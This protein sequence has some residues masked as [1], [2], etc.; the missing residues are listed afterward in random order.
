[1]KRSKRVW[2]T[3]EV[4]ASEF[5]I[6]PRTLADRLRQMGISAGKEGYSTQQ[7]VKAIYGDMAGERLRLV[8][9]QADKL[10]LENSKERR[11]AVSLREL[12]PLLNR[13][14]I[15][16]KAEITSI[17]YIERDDKDKILLKCGELCELALTDRPQLERDVQA[18][19]E[20]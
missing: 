7:M 12:L 1:M 9:E 18:S 16:I 3:V 13:A 15:A 5:K 19:P 11:D 17:T 4:A 14:V 8:R 2:W 6:N 10:A 20:V